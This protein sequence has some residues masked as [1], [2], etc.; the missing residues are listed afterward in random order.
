MRTVLSLILCLAVS[1]VF[2]S[3]SYAKFKKG[4]KKPKPVAACYG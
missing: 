4:V 3:P 2:A 1:L